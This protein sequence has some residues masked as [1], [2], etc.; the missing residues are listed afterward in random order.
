MHWLFD[1]NF[2]QVTVSGYYYL[3]VIILHSPD[4]FMY[5]L[6]LNTILGSPVVIFWTIKM[7]VYR[8][9]VMYLVGKDFKVHRCSKKRER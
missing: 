9:E 8:P 7:K 2:V 5:S 4:S 1:L 6:A 3:I